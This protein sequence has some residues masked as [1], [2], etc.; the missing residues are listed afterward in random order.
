LAELHRQRGTAVILRQASATAKA[1]VGSL[2]TA[3]RND[4]ADRACFTGRNWRATFNGVRDVLLR[5]GMA[6]LHSRQAVFDAVQKAALEAL[7][8]AES[9]ERRPLKK[10]RR[11][12]AG[13]TNDRND[14]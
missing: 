1:A 6:A 8:R 9:A 12:S 4:L 13:V 2:N 5:P 10:S 3:T 7:T 11:R 14:T